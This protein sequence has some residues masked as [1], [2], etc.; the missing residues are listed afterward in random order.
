M[1]APVP[2]VPGSIIHMGNAATSYTF[3]NVGSGPHRLI[4]VVADGTH[5]PLQPLVVDTVDFVI[6]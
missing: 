1:G 2:T 5:M 4:A 3:E 6:E